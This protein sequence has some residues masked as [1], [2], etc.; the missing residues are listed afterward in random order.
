MTSNDKVKREIGAILTFSC[1]WYVF[2]VFSV[3]LLRISVDLGLSGLIW[4]Y[5]G[6][7]GLIW[8]FIFP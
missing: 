1:F 2:N 3:F 7:V 6:L 8:D 5:L 4:A